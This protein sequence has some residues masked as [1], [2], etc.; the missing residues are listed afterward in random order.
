MDL[1]RTRNAVAVAGVY[2]ITQ[3]STDDGTIKILSSQEKSDGS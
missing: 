3:K 1:K 2:V